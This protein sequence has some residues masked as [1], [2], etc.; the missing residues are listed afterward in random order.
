MPSDQEI[1][2]KF[3]KALKTDRIMML[4]LDGAEDGRAQ[5]MA[6]Q[7]EEDATSGPIYFF[8]TKN[9]GLVQ[10]MNQ[11]H[12]AIATFTSKGMDLFASINGTLVTDDDEATIDRLWSPYAAAWYEK[13]RQDPNL[14]LLR[15][16]TDGAEIWLNSN[17]VFAGIK[18]L[19]GIDPKQ[20]AKK[21]VAEVTL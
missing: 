4:G 11:S 9:N 2:A 8:A 3:W 1:E 6:S 16:D 10:A 7:L 21:N 5:P 20:D 18:S 14:Q 13:G 17:S 12:R 15:L 19:L